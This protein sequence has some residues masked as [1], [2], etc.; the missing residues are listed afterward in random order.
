MSY[1]SKLKP[2]LLQTL[3]Y[4]RLLDLVTTAVG[5]RAGLTELNPIFHVSGISGLILVNAALFIPLTAIYVATHFVERSNLHYLN[6]VFVG[7]LIAFVSISLYTVVW[8]NLR[9]IAGG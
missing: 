9:V 8:N 2:H 6:S 3:I 4:L 7:M 5:V 1:I